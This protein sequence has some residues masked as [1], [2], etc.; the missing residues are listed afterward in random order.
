MNISDLYLNLE[1]FLKR[2]E[3]ENTKPLIVILGPTASGKTGLSI[4]LA[5]KYNGEIISV[6]SRQVYKYMDIGTAKITKEEMQGIKHYLLDV[7]KPDQVFN[8][9]DFLQQARYL[10]SQIHS[11][12]KLP[13]LV[14]GTGLYISALIEN[15]QMNE[16]KPDLELRNQLELELKK[17]G[18]EYM[19]KKL[20]ELD[21]EAAKK[22]HVSRE[23]IY[24]WIR[25]GK[26]K[27][28]RIPSGSYRIPEEQ[29]IV[30]YSDEEVSNN[31]D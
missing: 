22:I 29:L 18:P 9:A 3:S 25:K 17:N 13:F 16:S 30:E 5:K 20:Q 11:K 10:I 8:L 7:V 12:N 31:D 24:A 26:L 23:T 14:G 19:Y 6:D 2:A 21:P 28:V 1:K 27:P 15:Y 4:N